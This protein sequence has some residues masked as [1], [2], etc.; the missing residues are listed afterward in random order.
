MLL[1]FFFFWLFNNYLIC[2]SFFS[3]FLN[4]LVYIFGIFFLFYFNYFN[5]NN[6][7]KKK[8]IMGPYISSPVTTKEILPD[9]NN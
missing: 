7:I 2:V 9:I 3:F 5:T 8:S 6:N 4:L 1:L